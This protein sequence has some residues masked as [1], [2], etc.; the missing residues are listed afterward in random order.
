VET[1]QYGLPRNIPDP[2][3]RQV[4]QACGFG[5]V[6]C[7]GSIVEYEHVDPA[8][9]DAKAHDPR[10]IALL[11]PGCHAKVTRNFLSKDTVK[12]AMRD[13]FCKKAGYASELLDVGKT[14]PKVV[15]AGLTL[16]NCQI[17]IAVRGIPLFL[18]QEAEATGAPFRLSAH[19]S[20]SRGQPS[21]EI[22]DNEW[23]VYGTNWDAEAVGGAIIIR[24]GPRHVSLRLVAS[25]PDGV[26]VEELD[27]HLAGFHFLGS[28]ETLTVHMPGGAAARSRGVSWITAGRGW[29]SD[30]RTLQSRPD[31]RW[32]KR[33]ATRA[34]SPS[35]SRSSGPSRRPTSRTWASTSRRSRSRR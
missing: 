10:S 9:V 32:Q 18:I 22:V 12:D 13:P 28:P 31:A 16:T 27:M 19:F 24:D 29:R 35:T 33:R 17:P 26:I 20:N 30:S 11:C 21:L 8:F 1:N 15:F 2:V 3:K 5:C 23:R 25:P 14:H 6:V 4:R 34:R 7:A